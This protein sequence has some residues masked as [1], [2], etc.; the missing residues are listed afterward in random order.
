MRLVL[1]VTSWRDYRCVAEGRSS[2]AITGVVKALRCSADTRTTQRCIQQVNNRDLE[3]RVI[4]FTVCI[5]HGKIKLITSPLVILPVFDI[6]PL[7]PF[8]YFR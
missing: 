3:D 8:C 5:M 7:A 4:I 1:D 6:L 2:T